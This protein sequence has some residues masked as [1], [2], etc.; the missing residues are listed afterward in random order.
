M[1]WILVCLL[2]LAVFASAQVVLRPD[3]R[4]LSD[5][6]KRYNDSILAGNQENRPADSLKIYN[7]SIGDYNYWTTKKSKRV[8]DTILNID[9]FYKQNVYQQ[10]L[11]DKQQFPNLGQALNPL[12]PV[13]ISDNLQLLPLGKSFMYMKEEDIKY[14]DVKTPI[15]EFILENGLKEGQFLSTTF[16]HNVHSRWNY[17]IQY[18]YLKSQGRYLNSLANNSNFVFSTNYKTKNNRYHLQ[19]N[20]VTHDLNNQENAGLTDESIIDFI[21]DNPNF[22]N[23][24]RMYINM[25]SAQSLFDERR[26]HLD[27]QFGLLSFNKSNDSIASDN[28]P[29]YLKHELNYK[30]QAFQYLERG[31]ESYYD[32]DVLEGARSNRKKFDELENKVSLGYQWSDR[33]TVEG[34]LLHQMKELYFDENLALENYTIP[35]SIKENRIG[36]QAKLNFDWSESIDLNADAFYT[37]GDHFGD[38]YQLNANIRLSPFT[39]YLLEGGLKLNSSMPSLNY[40]AHQSF[41]EDFNSYNPNFENQNTQELYAELSSQKIGLSVFGKILNQNNPVYID[42]N[43]QVEQL[44]G[45]SNY[46]SIGAREHYRFGKFGIDAQAQYQKVLDN[47]HVLPL[48]SI[49]ARGTVYYNTWEFKNHAHIQTGLTLRYYSKFNSREFFPIMNEFVLQGEN[50]REIGNYPQLDLFFN[51]RVDRMRFYIRGENLNSFFQRGEYFSTPLQ[52]ARDF[53]I[54]VGIHWFLFS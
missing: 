3:G 47:D 23:R 34:G 5:E 31:R 11:F 51:M 16:A 20:F 43:F 37:T 25:Q 49:L 53:K 13:D 40:F 2:N 21:T 38:Q 30:H 52:P 35:A 12:S 45:A 44:E 48:P 50:A 42:S 18:R 17:A 27:H 15:T 39:G 10:D 54:Q 41:Y 33:I 19:A 46:F 1:R 28:F 29:I 22:S 9:N 26:I 24:E 7:P 14:Y 32:S 6:E 8:L 4:S 36:L